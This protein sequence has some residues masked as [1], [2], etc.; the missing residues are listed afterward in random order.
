MRMGLIGITL[1]IVTAAHAG[2]EAPLV[3]ATTVSAL[4]I[5]PAAQVNGAVTLGDVLDFSSSDPR[6]KEALADVRLGLS[7]GAGGVLEISYPQIVDRL[8]AAGVNMSRVLMRGAYVCRVQVLA[9]SDAADP[10]LAT[11]GAT[12]ANQQASARVPDDAPLLRSVPDAVGGGQTLA[13]AIRAAVQREWKAPDAT[14][15]VAFERGRS[16]F[17]SLTSPP[18]EFRVRAVRGPKL[19]MREFK[20]T[21][22]RDGRIERTVSVFG[23]VSVERDVYVAAKPLSV[24]A[25]IR[26]DNVKRARRLF[27]S[28]AALGV[29][30]I[31]QVMGQRVKTFI[32]AGALVRAVDLK[33]ADM[34]QRSRPVTLYSDGQVGVRLT[35]TALDS[36][37]LGEMVRVRIG[38]LRG[39]R[40]VVRGV[41]TGVAR[42]RLEEDE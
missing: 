2:V 32:P 38:E 40:R 15:E 31:E 30:R 36:G 33:A 29:E 11:E 10:H 12:L 13:D 35:G 25:F 7:A 9:A 5:R 4:R 3:S 21:L 23:R 14:T 34:V 37:G 18:F 42:V 16:E 1:G 27:D 8:E 26:P 17:L 6:L 41:V 20:V 19:G 28:D 39:Q 22:Y 24:G